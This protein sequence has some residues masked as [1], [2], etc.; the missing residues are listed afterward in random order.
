MQV[1]M[2]H[3]RWLHTLQIGLKS[4]ALHK[5]R[6]AL[7]VLGVVFGVGSVIVMLSVGEGAR[8]AA[9]QQIEELGA[10]N[11]II[12]S[13]KPAEV[14]TDEQSDGIAT[15]GL[16]PQDVSR[17]QHF[18]PTVS[19][20]TPM[21]EDR[22]EMR[23][24][25]RKVTGRLVGVEPAF[26]ELNGLQLAAGS[27]ISELDNERCATVAVL[28]AQVADALFPFEDPI[29]RSIRIGED[30]Y[31]QVIGVTAP[32]AASP[33]VGNSLPAQDYGLDVYVPFST[34]KNRFGELVT[35]TSTGVR[36]RERPEIAQITLAVSDMEHVKSTAALVSQ[37]LA[38]TH[39]QPD[40]AIIVP[41]DLLEKAEQTQRIFTLVLGSIA[42][43]SLLVGGIGIMNIM[44]ATVTE[45]TREIGIRRALGARRGDIT[46]Q[47]LLE[48]ILLSTAGGTLG[49]GLGVGLSGVVA[50][51]FA[52]TTIVRLWS[53][54]LALAISIAVGVVFGTYPARQ[55]AMMDP[56]EALRH[57]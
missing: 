18:I 16:A 42:S 21:R 43:I 26:Q 57:E 28:A 20:V 37:L 47:F 15:Y 46:R 54:L 48:T 49:V 41:L 8:Q 50:Q 6:S 1:P 36:Q 5:L 30:R 27:F 38:E 31:F 53:P 17:L 52:M 33:R 25:A 23:Y 39:K 2:N 29:G 56:I 11:I 7:A 40:T 19:T 55:A 12:R 35:Y 3:T 14:P 51:S 32:R 45:R 10:T 22:K 9:I 34:D 13:V 4:L 24:Q 44:L